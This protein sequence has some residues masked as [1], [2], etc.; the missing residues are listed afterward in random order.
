MKI[1]KRNGITEEFNISKIE[2][3][4]LKAYVANNR[5][6][7][8]CPAVLESDF[9]DCPTVE[10]IQ[11][12]VIEIISRKDKDI[13]EKYR[14]YKDERNR[15]RI[16]NETISKYEELNSEEDRSNANANTALV[17]TKRSLIA[18]ETLKGMFKYQFLT[19]EELRAHE[20][21]FFYVHDIGSRYISLNCCLWN[22]ANVLEGGFQLENIHYTEPKRASSA[23]STLSDCV[24]QIGSNQHGGITTPNIDTVLVPYCQKSYDRWIKKLTEKFPFAGHEGIKEFA[25]EEVMDELEQ[26]F[27]GIEHTWNSISSGRGDFT[28]T[29]LTFGNDPN[30]WAIRV[31]ET[32][33]RVRK[34]GQGLPGH[35]TPVVFPKLV[36]LYNNEMHGKGKPY[37]FLFDEAIECTKIAQYPDYLSLDNSYI[38]DMYHKW[39]KVISPMGK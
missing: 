25:L 38:G 2:N 30:P 17:S 3:A 20:E 8:D 15:L 4:I 23:I 12:R 9:I 24:Q 29:T 36:F 31:S 18:T 6:I 13:A 1:V 28:F 10:A 7:G 33:M 37:E 32:I 26:G 39:G 35:K 34:Q 14:I 5:S 16:I 22:A 19:P 11:N 27:Q 21:G